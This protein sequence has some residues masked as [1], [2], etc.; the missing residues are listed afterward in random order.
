MSDESSGLP[1]EEPDPLPAEGPTCPD[2]GAVCR[3]REGRQCLR[4]GFD[5]DAPADS[6]PSQEPGDTDSGDGVADA[7]AGDDAAAD[8][9]VTRTQMDEWMWVA[10]AAP[11]TL[12]LVVGGFMEAPGLIRATAEVN[13]GN[14]FGAAV[15]GIVSVGLWSGAAVIA[16]A[17]LAWYWHRPVGHWWTAV[18][19]LVA[20]AAVANVAILID[21]PW[22]GVAFLARLVVGAAAFYFLSLMLMRLDLRRAGVLTAATIGAWLA[23]Q[24]LAR[25]TLFGG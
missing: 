6:S 23:L 25:I 19:R 12:A 2:C 10:L 1:L 21:A 13:F 9:I 18:R 7:E 24:G 11:A 5:A 22:R 15:R 3:G 4:C 17:A 20:I 16:L 8:A 14:R